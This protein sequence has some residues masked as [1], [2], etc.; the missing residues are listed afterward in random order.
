MILLFI[1]SIF[2]LNKPSDTLDREDI[3][4]I[5]HKRRPGHNGNDYRYKGSRGSSRLYMGGG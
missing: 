1:Y 4:N 3:D 2:F 5:R